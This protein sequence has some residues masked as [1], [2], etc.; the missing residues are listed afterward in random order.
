MTSKKHTIT[1]IFP[2]T[3]STINGKRYLFPGWIP[4]DD[5]VT[6][7]DVEHI[8]PYKNKTQSYLVK[9]SS[10]NTYEVIKSGITMTCNCPAGKFRGKCKHI[11]EIKNRTQE[12]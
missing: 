1:G 6:A 12:S 4:V 11:D 5:S 3:F 9:G 10:G 7:D 2:P 8:N